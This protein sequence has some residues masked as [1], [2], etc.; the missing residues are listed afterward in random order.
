MSSR[1]GII[2]PVTFAFLAVGTLFAHDYRITKRNHDAAEGELSLTAYVGGFSDRIADAMRGEPPAP[3]VADAMPV[4]LD[5]WTARAAVEGDYDTL[6]QIVPDEP[7]AVERDLARVEA[8]IQSSVAFQ[9]VQAQQT[10]GIEREMIVFERGD[11]M[12]MVSI[13][14]RPARIFNQIGGAQLE[15]M[16]DILNII[17]DQE[18]FGNVGGLDFL[19]SPVKGSTNARQI[20]GHLSRQVD[21]T[22]ITNSDDIAAR[23]VL[24]EVDLVLLNGMVEEPVPEV[25][26]DYV[27]PPR[28][29]PK[30]NRG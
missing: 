16:Q 30:V 14:F 26:P 6:T 22:V 5:G 23:E 13:I 19:V 24:S 18:S 25:D 1:L 21:V 28:V 4:V 12:M 2:L 17:P 8:E 7:T 27:P 29:L 9:I 3:T 10:R 15:I 11:D 20:V